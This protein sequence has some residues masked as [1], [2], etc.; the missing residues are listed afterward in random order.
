MSSLL[1]GSRRTNKQN[2]ISVLPGN[3]SSRFSSIRGLAAP[4]PVVS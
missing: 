1:C 2:A 4:A 3:K